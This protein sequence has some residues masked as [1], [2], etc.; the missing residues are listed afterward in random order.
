M[1]RISQKRRLMVVKYQNQRDVD[2]LDTCLKMCCLPHVIFKEYEFVGGGALWKIYI[3][4]GSLTWEQVMTEVNRVHATKF[5]FINDGSYIQD[6]RLYTPLVPCDWLKNQRA[7]IM[8]P[9]P[10]YESEEEDTDARI[11]LKA[12]TLPNLKPCYGKCNL[13]IWKYNGGCS[14]WNGWGTN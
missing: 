9:C 4:R 12:I 14:E 13:C 7:V 10:R 3:D 11:K 1:K 6:G 5:E 8:P 2:R